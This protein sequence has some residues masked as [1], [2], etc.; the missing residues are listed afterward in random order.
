MAFVLVICARWYVRDAMQAAQSDDG[1]VAVM[2]GPRA[3]GTP[4]S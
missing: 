4:R 3:R 1:H 2:L